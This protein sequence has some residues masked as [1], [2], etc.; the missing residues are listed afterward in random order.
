[1]S[2]TAFFYG[3]LMAP[4][5]LHRVIWGSPTPPTPTHAS[6]LHIRPAIL[7]AH[8]RRKV[9]GADYP[10]VVPVSCSEASVRGTLV[11][12][13]TDGDLWRLDV[14]EG[15]EYVRSKVRVRVLLPSQKIQGEGGKE[16]EGMGDVTQKEEDNVEGEEV[17][18]ETYIWVAGEHRLE[19][20]EWDFTEFVREKMGRWVG[21]VELEDVDNAVAAA[22]GDP[23]GGRGANG[24]ITRQLNQES[25]ASR[26]ILESA[27]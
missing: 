25:R 22:Q 3:T 5:V 21:G 17:E 15:K 24:D 13:L 12:G 7:H 11:Q 6:L 23:T 26:E 8:Q 9:K 14:F 27:V 16:G 18:A 4:P 20:D 1:M 19:G 10:G 2:H